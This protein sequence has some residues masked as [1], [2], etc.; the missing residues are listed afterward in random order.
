MK[1]IQNAESEAIKFTA[2]KINSKY[3][4]RY[5][6]LRNEVNKYLQ[7]LQETFQEDIQPQQEENN[8]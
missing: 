4:G 3:L 7:S 2:K 6:A 1:T 5:K 8:S